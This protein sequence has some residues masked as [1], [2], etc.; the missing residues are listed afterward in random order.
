MVFNRFKRLMIFWYMPL[1]HRKVSVFF[2][3]IDIEIGK[4]LLK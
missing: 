4:N 3:H 1:G 2:I